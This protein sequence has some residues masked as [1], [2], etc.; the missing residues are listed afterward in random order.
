MDFSKYLQSKWKLD[1][2]SLHP[3]LLNRLKEYIRPGMRLLD[4]GAG[5][6]AML[7]RLNEQLRDCEYHALDLDSELLSEIE[8][9]PLP[10]GVT[11]KTVAG[12][13]QDF[14]AG[15]G[16]EAYDVIISHMF[17]D[18]VNI[19]SMMQQIRRNLKNGGWGYFSMVYDGNSRFFPPHPMDAH[20]L[21]LYN[22]S[23]KDSRRDGSRAGR[24]LLHYCSADTGLKV[25][26]AAASDWMIV[27]RKD[28]YADGEQHVL[29]SLLHFF[30]QVLS[31][32][33]KPAAPSAGQFQAWLST[34]TEQMETHE[35]GFAN[36]QVDL[37]VKRI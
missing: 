11:L 15:S 27:P 5:N 35:L 14:L 30:R 25:L 34:R 22:G 20:V 2:K 17:M 23:M 8:S 4:L 16:D 36:S 28:G 10:E 9:D 7:R 12:D 19:P 21:E 1:S 37:L 29:S 31:S 13:A 3:R 26:D 32:E 6:G 18:L 33:V 24:E